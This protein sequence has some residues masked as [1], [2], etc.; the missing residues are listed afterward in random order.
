MITKFGKHWKGG[1]QNL[2][3]GAS[4]ISN[5]PPCLG[6]TIFSDNDDEIIYAVERTQIATNSF[7]KFALRRLYAGAL[8]SS[9]RKSHQNQSFLL[10]ISSE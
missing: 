7:I 10:T 1:G 8:H 4:G 2:N 9:E 3:E 6:T 5:H